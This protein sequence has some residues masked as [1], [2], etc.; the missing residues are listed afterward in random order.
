MNGQD[1]RRS[2]NGG[3]GSELRDFWPHYLSRQPPTHPGRRTVYLLSNGNGS[4]H[5]FTFDSGGGTQVP[6]A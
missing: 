5:S 1:G 3:R 2:A 4:E 6:P